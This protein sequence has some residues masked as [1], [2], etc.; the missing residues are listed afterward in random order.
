MVSAVEAEV[1]SLFMN[2][3]KVIPIRHT[4]IKMG[5]PQPPT[6]LKTDNTTAQGILTKQFRQKRSKSID[7]RFWWLKD[8]IE[9]KQFKAEWGPDKENLADYTTKFCITSHHKK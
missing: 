9:Q 3:N 4:L 1:A 7:M 6:P 2:A 5:H 8:R